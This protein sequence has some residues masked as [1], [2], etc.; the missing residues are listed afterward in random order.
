M[1]R[2]TQIGSTANQV[3]LVSQRRKK[4]RRIEGRACF[5]SMRRLGKTKTS[6]TLCDYIVPKTQRPNSSSPH[7]KP[8]NGF[9]SSQIF[10]ERGI[11]GHG[12]RYLSRTSWLHVIMNSCSV[13]TTIPVVTWLRGGQIGSPVQIACLSAVK[14]NAT[15]NITFP[16]AVSVGD[17]EFNTSRGFMCTEPSV[18]KSA[19]ENLRG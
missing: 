16:R 7:F 13:S 11:I 2:P 9:D 15:P 12:I 18:G 14:S 1:P 17:H 19:A 5:N 4:S 6:E 8:V 10:I 3:Q